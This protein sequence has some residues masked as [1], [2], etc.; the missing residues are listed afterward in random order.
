[1]NAVK[2][3][4]QL[5]ELSADLF[6]SSRFSAHPLMPRP[7]RS[8]RCFFLKNSF[9]TSHVASVRHPKF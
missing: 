4:G 8:L 2:V 7:S 3:Q 9:I 5:S 1:M 6:T